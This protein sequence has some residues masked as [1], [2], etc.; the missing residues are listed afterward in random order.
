[1]KE[2]H[3]DKDQKDGEDGTCRIASCLNIFLKRQNERNRQRPNR[4]ETGTCI[5]FEQILKN[6][7]ANMA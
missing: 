2:I 1:M 4:E 3:K 7:S 6:Y 5:G